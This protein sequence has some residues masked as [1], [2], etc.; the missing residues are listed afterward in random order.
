M[1][2]GVSYICPHDKVSAVDDAEKKTISHLGFPLLEIDN[3]VC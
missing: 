2:Y 1:L 3:P